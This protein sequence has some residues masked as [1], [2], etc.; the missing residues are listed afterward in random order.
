MINS[1]K[2]FTEIDVMTQGGPLD[3][4]TT[5]AYLLYQNA[6][7]HFQMGESLSHRIITLYHAVDSDMDSIPVC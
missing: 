5:L 2:S 1:L 3:S 4:T 7:Q 6:F